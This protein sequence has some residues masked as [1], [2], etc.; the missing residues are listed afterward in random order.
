MVPALSTADP[1]GGPSMGFLN[2]LT[3]GQAILLS[4]GLI[5][6]FGFEFVNGFHD[7]ANAV[8]TVIYTKAMRP[9]TAVIWSGFCNFLGVILGGIGVAYSNVYLPPVALLTGININTLMAMV[10]SA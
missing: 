1:A 6:A 5:I 10:F 9:T 4:A 2:D 8:A 7:T 3:F